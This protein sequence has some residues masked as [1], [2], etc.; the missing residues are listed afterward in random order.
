MYD[1]YWFSENFYPPFSSSSLLYKSSEACYFDLCGIRDLE[2]V[3]DHERLE[4]CKFLK[5]SQ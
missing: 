5:I 2:M 3:K 4:P 1:N